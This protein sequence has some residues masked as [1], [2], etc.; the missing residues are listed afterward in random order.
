MKHAPWPFVI[1]L[2]GMAV[3]AAVLLLLIPSMFGPD[4]GQDPGVIAVP[5]VLVAVFAAGTLRWRPSTE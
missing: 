4:G 5:A 1:S 3:S 2:L